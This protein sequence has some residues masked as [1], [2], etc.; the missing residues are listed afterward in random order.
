MSQV[1]NKTIDQEFTGLRSV[2][3]PLHK[4]EFKKFWPMA[5]M[6]FCLVFI[7]TILRNLK[8]ALIILAPG[9]GA[10]NIA[11]LKI[12]MQRQ[13]KP[14]LLVM[15][16]PME[17]DKLMYFDIMQQKPNVCNKYPILY[18]AIMTYHQNKVN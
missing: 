12:K 9:G 8:D 17:F 14:F 3:W 1:L 2:L 11:Y 6:I 15:F 10:E 4:H 13:L 5:L 7:S 18:L 16:V